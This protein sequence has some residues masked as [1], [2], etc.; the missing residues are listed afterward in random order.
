MN[1]EE[2]ITDE[3]ESRWFAGI[4]YQLFG[5]RGN[6]DVRR[7]RLKAR[8]TARTMAA[9]Q[10]ASIVQR[11]LAQPPKPPE[12]KPTGLAGVIR[13]TPGAINNTNI[14]QHMA[15]DPSKRPRPAA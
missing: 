1:N 9:P 5:R 11:T 2:T 8:R 13:F 10:S 4:L 15:T 7:A 12:P 3:E 6:Y 14:L